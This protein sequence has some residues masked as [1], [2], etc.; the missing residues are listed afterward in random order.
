MTHGSSRQHHG[1]AAEPLKRDFESGPTKYHKTDS[2][3]GQQ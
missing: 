3:Y 1:I 2:Y